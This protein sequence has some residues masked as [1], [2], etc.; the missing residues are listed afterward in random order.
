MNYE[1]EHLAQ[2]LKSARLAKGMSQRALSRE[3]QLPQS[4]ISK[5]EN[6][7]VDLRL[8]SLVAIARVL[9][10]E[11][12]L[13]PRKSLPA[14][15]SVTRAA[16]RASGIAYSAAKGEQLR[17]AAEE[18]VKVQNNLDRTPAIADAPNEIRQI[19]RTLRELRHFQFNDGAIATVHQVGK[20]IENLAHEQDKTRALQIAL[21]KLQSL[22]NRL[23]HSTAETTIQTDQ[24]PPAYSLDTDDHD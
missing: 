21:R 23:A 1:I 22:R 11:L 24:T 9:G 2:Q 13:V 12:I 7:N 16:G 3:T 5:I 17:N 20:M 4:H 8:S 10:L 15:E 19:S 18:L 14:V 6:G